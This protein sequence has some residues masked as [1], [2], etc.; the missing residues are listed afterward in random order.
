[1]TNQEQKRLQDATGWLFLR[2]LHGTSDIRK[3][4]HCVWQVALSQ[5]STSLCTDE[6]ADK[7]W[8]CQHSVS[9]HVS[10]TLKLDDATEEAEATDSEPGNQTTTQGLR[11]TSNAFSDA[12]PR[13]TPSHFSGTSISQCQGS[14]SSMVTVL[15]H[16]TA[17]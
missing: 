1:M 17:P 7:R 8:L 11:A 16:E 4:G 9:G 6:V 2:S 3:L 10:L 12:P 13:Q 15:P 14:P 5:C